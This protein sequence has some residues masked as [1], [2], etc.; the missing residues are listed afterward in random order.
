MLRQIRRMVVSV[1]SSGLILA[2]C[3]TDATQQQGGS[4]GNADAKYANDA[5]YC[6][7]LADRQEECSGMA[8][9]PADAAECEKGVACEWNTDRPELVIGRRECLANSECS[10]NTSDCMEAVYA[11]LKDTPTSIAYRS[12]CEAKQT[13]CY[14]TTGKGFGKDYCEEAVTKSDAMLG[15]LAE[16]IAKPCD[17]ITTCFYELAFETQGSCL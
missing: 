13:E 8:V 2:G 16:C 15:K 3:G 12:D 5:T 9:D 17:M 14:M 6:Q 10:E 1:M 7:A 4:G 11:S